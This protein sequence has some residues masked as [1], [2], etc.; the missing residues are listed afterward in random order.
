MGEKAGYRKRTGQ[1]EFRD[2][3]FLPREGK[4][5]IYGKDKRPNIEGKKGALG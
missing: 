1:K 3:L 4:R 2:C 5:E